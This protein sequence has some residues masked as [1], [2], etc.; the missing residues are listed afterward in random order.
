MTVK[1]VLR[2]AV[3]ALAAASTPFASAPA[4]AGEGHWS[5]G[6]GVQCRVILGF[7][8]CSKRV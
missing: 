8:I 6:H 1:T 3:I 2:A 4:Y 5:V 7:V